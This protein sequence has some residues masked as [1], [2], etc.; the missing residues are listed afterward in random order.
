M[1]QDPSSSRN[2][3]RYRRRDPRSRRRGGRERPPEP[4]RELS[5]GEKVQ[6]F[7]QGLFGKRQQPPPPP[8]RLG[9]VR[10][11]E[12]DREPRKVA[13]PPPKSEAPMFESV[14]EPSTPRLY[15]G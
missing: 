9:A 2:F 13:S 12:R 1:S 8:A 7:F 3:G 15:V 5:F 4:P 10:E 6:A 11:R 14:V